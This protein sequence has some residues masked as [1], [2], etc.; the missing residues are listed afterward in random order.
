MLPYPIMNCRVHVLAIHAKTALNGTY[1]LNLDAMPR[2]GQGDVK[3]FGDRFLNGPYSDRGF[4]FT[5]VRFPNQSMLRFAH[6]QGS[7]FQ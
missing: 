4:D 7:G 3:S 5:E 6:V 1:H 2:I